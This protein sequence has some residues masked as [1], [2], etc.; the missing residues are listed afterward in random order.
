MV[1]WQVVSGLLASSK[2]E[3][4][5]GQAHVDLKLGAVL[6]NDSGAS[7][8]VERFAGQGVIGLKFVFS[9]ERNSEI[10]NRAIFLGELEEEPFSFNFQR[11]NGSTLKTISVAPVFELSDGKTKTT[12]IVDTYTLQPKDFGGNYIVEESDDGL[13]VN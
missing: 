7:L 9:D 1:I 11:L 12:D 8:R 10:I 13:V 5:F 2:D 6:V 4:I 3:I